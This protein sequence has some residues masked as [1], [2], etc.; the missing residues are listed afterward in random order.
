MYGYEPIVRNAAT[1]AH[2]IIYKYKDQLQAGIIV[3]GVDDVDG[4][5]IYEVTLGGSMLKQD[6]CL[7]GSGSTYIYGYVDS[8]YN[9]NMT[10][11]EGE[12]FV[13]RGTYL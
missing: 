12:E 4:A 8:N 9:P 13:R 2:T 11:E 3:A 6:V 5:S 10:P 7:G 1:L